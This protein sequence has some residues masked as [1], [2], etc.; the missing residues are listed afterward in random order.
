M[1]L[2]H[3]FLFTLVAFTFAY[4]LQYTKIVTVKI[5]EKNNFSYTLYMSEEEYENLVFAWRTYQANNRYASQI[6]RVVALGDETELY[7]DIIECI[8]AKK[9]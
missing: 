1:K 3:L 7:L 2:K 4:C 8:E 5:H 6:F 9:A